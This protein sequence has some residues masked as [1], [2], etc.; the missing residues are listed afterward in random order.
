MKKNAKYIYWS[1]VLV[2]VSFIVA[3]GYNIGVKLSNAVSLTNDNNV[4]NNVVDEN[5][6][7]ILLNIV[8]VS[9]N[10]YAMQNILY[11]INGIVSDSLTNDDI[12]RIIYIYSKQRGIEVNAADIGFGSCVVEN[13]EAISLADIDVIKRIYGITV[14]DEQFSDLFNGFSIY[15]GMNIDNSNFGIIQDN[16]SA[17][18]DGDDIVLTGNLTVN[19][20]NN[21]LK[22]KITYRFKKYSDIEY[23]LY[24]IYSE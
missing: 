11:R 15:Q 12:A 22:K 4:E 24:S 17:K 20:N 5:T 13:C 14:P 18:Y 10:N 3:S 16:F 2:G 8:G 7:E 23:Y 6:K 21:I 9:D 1:I 19:E